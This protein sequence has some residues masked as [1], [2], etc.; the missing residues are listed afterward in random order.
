PDLNRLATN[1]VLMLPRRRQAVEPR[2]VRNIVEWVGRGGHMI[3]EAEML[4]VADPMLER[5][6]VKRALHARM[7][8]LLNAR[9]YE[10]SV[11][12]QAQ[13][14]KVSFPYEITLDPGDKNVILKVADKESIK[15]VSFRH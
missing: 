8:A 12:E 7:P 6:N 3:V 1:D 15:L 2:Q 10:A 4:G 13:P 9:I 14:L 5:F 11:S